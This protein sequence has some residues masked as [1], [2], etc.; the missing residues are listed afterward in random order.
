MAQAGVVT[1]TGEEG[2]VGCKAGD[3][4]EAGDGGVASDSPGTGDGS[5][6][7]KISG[8]SEGGGVQSGVFEGVVGADLGGSAGLDRGE[9]RSSSS[10][11]QSAAVSPRCVSSLSSLRVAI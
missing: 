6:C 9:R 1:R 4:G 3:V 7:A 8:C 10:S 11:P 2:I 5:G